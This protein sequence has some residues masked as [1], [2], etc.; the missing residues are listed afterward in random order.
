MPT[1]LDPIVEA[2]FALNGRPGAYA[3]PIGSGVSTGAGI[4]TGW[5]I[6]LAL[7]GRVAELTEEELPTV[8]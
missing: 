1:P 2:A 7:I 3:A 5:E 4:P 6:V 8:S